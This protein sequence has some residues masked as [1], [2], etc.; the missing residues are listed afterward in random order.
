MTERTGCNTTLGRVGPDYS[1]GVLPELTYSSQAATF[2]GLCVHPLPRQRRTLD[3]SKREL[4]MASFKRIIIALGVM[5][6][7]AQSP[8][9]QTKPFSYQ[10]ILERL[11]DNQHV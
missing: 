11:L 9:A 3:R 10:S 8:L 1:V 5:L 4:R 6:F 7:F 2:G